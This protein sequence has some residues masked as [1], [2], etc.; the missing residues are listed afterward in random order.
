MAARL[1]ARFADRTPVVVTLH[2]REIVG[3]PLK[4]IAGALA[5][6]ARHPSLALVLPLHPNPAV[7]EELTAAL[8]DLDNV[9]LVGPLGCGDFVSLLEHCD[10]VLTDSGELQEEAL[11]LG[12]PAL[13]LR[14]TTERREG[15][16]S[17]GV[18]FA[19]IV[20]EWIAHHVLRRV[21]DNGALHAM[22]KPSRSYGAGTA[23]PRIVE[24]LAPENQ[25]R[26]YL[27]D[28]GTAGGGSGVGEACVNPADQVSLRRHWIASK[29]RS[30]SSGSASARSLRSLAISCWDLSS[31]APSCAA[32]RA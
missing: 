14:A 10:L 21:N 28:V 13:I 24:L 23:T 9:A 29:P 3:G 1:R 6:L 30:R 27:A 31:C 11:E 15:L 20:P 2:R 18:C 12:T 26:L 25:T 5:G 8:G 22:G 7:R 4:G 17:G 32:R 19:G 16:A